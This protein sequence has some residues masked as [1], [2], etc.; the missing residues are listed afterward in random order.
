MHARISFQLQFFVAVCS[1]VQ[2][3][4]SVAVELGRDL[5]AT[6]WGQAVSMLLQEAACLTKPCSPT[7][8]TRR[9]SSRLQRGHWRNPR[10]AR[11]TWTN[12][13]SHARHTGHAADSERGHGAGAATVGSNRGVATNSNRRATL[14][15]GHPDDRRGRFGTFAVWSP[16]SAS[17]A[18]LGAAT[19][20]AAW[21]GSIP[22]STDEPSNAAPTPPEHWGPTDEELLATMDEFERQEAED[23]GA[24]AQAEEKGEP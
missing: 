5:Y 6:G 16:I 18:K 17:R 13:T 23:L 2:G 11:G 3:I 22:S 10:H 21:S 19:G 24:A 14:R 1:T 4:S 7:R 15:S 8:S 20:A 12:H 9:M